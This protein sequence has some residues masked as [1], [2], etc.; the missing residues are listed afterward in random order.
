MALSKSSLLFAKGVYWIGLS[1]FHLYICY[2]LLTMGHQVVALL[3]LFAGFILLF[4]MY[5]LFFPNNGSSSWPPYVTGCPDYLTMIG[6]NACVDYVG[7]NSPLLKKADPSHPP[8]PGDA[9]YS[10]YV[11]NSSGTVPQ[12]VARAQQYGLSWE[13]LV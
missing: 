9:D 4:I 12:K 6:P 2:Q 10:S 7:L 3:W 5:P 8:A 13:G 1:L 11:F